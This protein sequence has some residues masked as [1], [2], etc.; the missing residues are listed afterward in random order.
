MGHNVE[1]QKFRLDSL[2]KY[3]HKSAKIKNVDRQYVEW[4]KS[5]TGICMYVSVHM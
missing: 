2:T 4:D 5:L 3:Q 1:W